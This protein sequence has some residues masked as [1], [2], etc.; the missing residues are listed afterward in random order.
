MERGVRRVL[1]LPGIGPLQ[2]H[3]I[4]FTDFLAGFQFERMLLAKEFAALTAAAELH[5]PLRK[6]RGRTRNSREGWRFREL[7]ARVPEHVLTRSIT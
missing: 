4:W 1:L 6:A 2:A 5:L 7:L 3:C